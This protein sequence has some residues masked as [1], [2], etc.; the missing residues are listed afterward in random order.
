NVRC[1]VCLD[2]KRG[3]C[4]SHLGKC[5]GLET[6]TSLRILPRSVVSVEGIELGLE[7]KPEGYRLAI[8]APPGSP[9]F[10]GFEGSRWNQE[11]QSLL[12]G[13][14]NP[15]NASVLRFRLPWLRPKLLGLQTSAGLG[16][17]LGLA[18]PGHVRAVRA[19]GGS[20]A[21]IFPQQSIREMSRTGRTPRQ[22][23]G[24]ATRGGIAGGLEGGFGAD[25][26]H[27]EAS[28]H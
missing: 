27:L 13:P 5:V 10:E 2:R 3:C 26:E 8:L 1:E 17:R 15:R 21:P 9:F 22:E 18:T 12:V 11:S 19:T 4:M 24:G 7:R 23:M 14:A 16:D 6:I 25:A 28:E 20:V